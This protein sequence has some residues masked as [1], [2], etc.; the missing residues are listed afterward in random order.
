MSWRRH[1]CGKEAWSIQLTYSDAT[2]TLG[3]SSG[4]ER[5]QRAGLG[6]SN[7]AHSQER[8]VSSAWFLETP[9]QLL[10][11]ELWVRGLLRLIRGSHS[12]PQC[13]LWWIRFISREL[14]F[15]PWVPHLYDW[16]PVKTLD[17][18][19][20]VSFPEDNAERVL[21]HTDAR[22][23]RFPG[24]SLEEDA[25]KLMLD[26]SWLRVFF[27]SADSTLC[28]FSVISH[29]GEHPSLSDSCGSFWWLTEPEGGL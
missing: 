16:L 5:V 22:I 14:E 17:P 25:W 8:L 11:A 24:T 2:S 28:P 7:P 19:S 23:M 3:Y 15:V 13:D 27:L 9:G 21:S 4:Q 1:S 12:R 26:F 10:G 6:C 29:N 18:K 20:W